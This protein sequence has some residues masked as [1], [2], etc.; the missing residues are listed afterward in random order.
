MFR[1][2]FDEIRTLRFKVISIG[3]KIWKRTFG[4][5]NI[6]DYDRTKRAKLDKRWCLPL[7]LNFG[8]G[9]KPP[10]KENLYYFLVEK[11]S[12]FSQSFIFYIT[13]ITE[14]L[15][16][17]IYFFRGICRKHEENYNWFCLWWRGRI[18]IAWSWRY[19]A[20]W[21]STQCSICSICM[22]LS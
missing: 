3:I 18:C 7:L 1:I 17:S 20:A 6:N 16:N 19:I 9:V 4:I 2:Q 22:F 8:Q 12:S 11:V 14:P 15:T 21:H 5:H 13:S 10:K